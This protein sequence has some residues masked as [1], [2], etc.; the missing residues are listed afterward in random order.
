MDVITAELEIF[1]PRWGHKDTYKLELTRES[2]LITQGPRSAKSTWR[3]NLDPEWSG[4]KLEDILRNDSIYPPGIFQDLVE[5]AWLSW[6]NGELGS[7]A[8]DEELQIGR[9][10]V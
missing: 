10:H 7:S 8:V 9:A 1:S 2:L 4:E 5:H 3:E 6:R